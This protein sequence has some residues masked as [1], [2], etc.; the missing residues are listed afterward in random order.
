MNDAVQEIE[1]CDEAQTIEFARDFARGLCAGDI[2]AFHGD[3][4]MGKSVFCRAIIRALCKDQ[5]MDVPSPTYTIVQHY[6]YESGVI[7]HFDMYRL[8]SPEEVY[9]TGWDEALA[10]GIVLV[11][12]PSRLG[13]LLPKRRI[14]V[15]LCAISTDPNRRKIEIRRHDGK[16]S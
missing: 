9:E 10:E 3:L 1:T 6:E 11:E 2:V 7:W 13:K 15:T 16:N 5:D 14:D 4:G 8:S 12:W